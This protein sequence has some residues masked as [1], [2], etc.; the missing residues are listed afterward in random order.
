MSKTTGRR[1]SISPTIKSLM[2][3]YSDET[4]IPLSRICNNAL[5]ELLNSNQLDV[6]EGV[7]ENGDSSLGTNKTSQ[8]YYIQPELFEEIKKIVDVLQPQYPQISFSSILEQALQKY[9]EKHMK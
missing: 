1:V 3:L 8:L 2:V 9:L 7:R 4:G 5:R 6:K